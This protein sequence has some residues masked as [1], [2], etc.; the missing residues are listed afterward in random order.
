M[1]EEEML[2][3]YVW[4]S[5]RLLR[6]HV[7]A[8]VYQMT[9][10]IGTEISSTASMDINETQKLKSVIGLGKKNYF[11]EKLTLKIILLKVWNWTI[12]FEY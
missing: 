8:N 4:A 7:F 3:E 9:V 1:Y 6:I 11:L 5:I 12:L 2:C 10:F